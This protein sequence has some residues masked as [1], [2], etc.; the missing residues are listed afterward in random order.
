MIYYQSFVN[1]NLQITG[2]RATERKID[3]DPFYMFDIDNL[4]ETIIVYMK[5]K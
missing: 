5:L 1:A 3:S 4:I 2:I